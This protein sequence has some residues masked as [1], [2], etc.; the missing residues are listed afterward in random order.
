VSAVA[1]GPASPWISAATAFA[2]GDA[3][4]AAEELDRI[5]SVADASYARLKSTDAVEIERALA[6][7]RTVEATAHVAEAKQRLEALRT[8][9]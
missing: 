7:Y 1:S 4:A 8:V 3:V 9:G 6:F 2:S 5:G